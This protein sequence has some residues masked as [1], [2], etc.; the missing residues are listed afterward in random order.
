MRQW[1]R[2]LL[3]SIGVGAIATGCAGHQPPPDPID[4]TRHAL[5]LGP[6]ARLRVADFFRYP[7]HRM[8]RL[9]AFR[10]DVAILDGLTWAIPSLVCSTINGLSASLPRQSS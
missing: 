8:A 5:C 1:Q 10:E 3:G 2:V 6:F 7:P 4:A 9:T